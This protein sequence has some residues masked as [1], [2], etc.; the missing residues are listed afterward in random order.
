MDNILET[1]LKI[2]ENEGIKITQ[3]EKKI[4]ASKGVLSRAIANNSDIQSKWFL[5]LVENYPQY[6]PEWLL[7]GKGSMLRPNSNMEEKTV[8]VKSGNNTEIPLVS[9]R[10]VAGLG[11][12]EFHISKSDIL[13]YYII[14]KWRN[15]KIDFMIEVEGMSMITKYSPGDIVACTIIRETSFI[16]YGKVHVLATKD[17]GLLVKR[18]KKSEIENCLLMVS[19]NPDY[20]PFDIPVGE[21]DGIALVR[22]GI[23]VD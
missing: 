8:A 18:I 17:Q 14:P 11:N 4:G 15:K 20:P 3:L 6:N 19:D 13:D 12:S 5:K 2:A 22:G 23:W 10:A 7:T 21:I 1:F 9:T 16:Q